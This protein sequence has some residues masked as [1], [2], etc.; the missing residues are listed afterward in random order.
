MLGLEGM[1]NRMMRLGRQEL[2]YERYSTLDE[3]MDEIESV[4]SEDVQRLAQ[5]LLPVDRF[6]CVAVCPK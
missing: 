5:N 3:V 2:F 1:T 4:K 6:S